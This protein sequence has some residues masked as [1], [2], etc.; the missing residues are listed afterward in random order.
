[1]IE[2]AQRDLFDA[3]THY[4]Q[5]RDKIVSFAE[6]SVVNWRCATAEMF[7]HCPLFHAI[8]FR[9]TGWWQHADRQWLPKNAKGAFL[10][11]LDADGN[12]RI[13]RASNQIRIFNT[14]GRIADE[15]CYGGA[16]PLTR[17]ILENTQV[18]AV[19]RYML[20]PHQYEFE[21]F[22]YCG[23]LCVR[24]VEKS[25]Y[26]SDGEWVQ[27]TWTTVCDYEYDSRGL[28][29]AYRDM[30]KLSGGRTLVYVRP[31]TNTAEDRSC[32]SR[33]TLVAH[34]I[35]HSDNEPP[36]QSVYSFAYGLEMSMDSEW[37]IDTVLLTSPD[38][39]DTITVGTGVTSMGSV[40]GGALRMPADGSPTSL[41]NAGAKWLLVDTSDSNRAANLRM[42]LDAGLSV[43]LAVETPQD[44]AHMLEGIEKSAGDQVAISFK[45]HS[46]CSP[47]SAQR[48]ASAIRETLPHQCIEDSRIV[49]EANLDK[50]NVMDY[51]SQPDV[52]GVV[53]GGGDVSY[54]LAILIQLALNIQ[55]GD[56]KRA[57]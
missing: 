30:G 11:G 56:W 5:E 41:I 1:M 54:T 16:I 3:A 46:R 43:I 35:A 53:T 13:I 44:A 23:G 9:G 22:E 20:Y 33:R 15:I 25:S 36:G 12:V 7:G 52:D 40:Y 18:V 4:M 19:Y 8:G 38:L 17:Y 2:F 50:K 34:K 27:A 31:A 10:H 28:I 47:E 39:I 51:V 49:I 32:L 57:K 29:R 6:A 37:P 26:L 21:R 45:V 14:S 42:A 48:I 24:S 55:G